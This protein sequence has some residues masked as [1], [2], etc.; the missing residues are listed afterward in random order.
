MIPELECS[1]ECKHWAMLHG[2]W[3]ICVQNVCGP[4]KNVIRANKGYERIS[5]KRPGTGFVCWDCLTPKRKLPRKQGPGPARIPLLERAENFLQRR[6]Y[7]RLF[8]TLVQSD[9][10]RKSFIK[11]FGQVLREEVSHILL[12]VLSEKK[13]YSDVR[14]RERCN[15]YKGKQNL[16]TGRGLVI[17]SLSGRGGCIC[18]CPARGHLIFATHFF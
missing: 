16:R 12:L 9:V 17:F 7:M 4:L 13:Y 6:Q 3:Q 5:L 15:K 10:A 11:V 14:T 1:L 2:R 18:S 8:R